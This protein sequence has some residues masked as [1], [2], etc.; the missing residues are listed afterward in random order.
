[1]GLLIKNG[2]VVTAE[3]LSVGDVRCREGR[4]VELGAGLPAAGERVVDASGQYV[5]PGGVD[6]HVHMELPVAGT[7]SSDDFETGTAAAL[8]G[9]TTTVIDFVHPERGE[10]F[11]SALAAR[12]R[13]AARSVIDYGLHMAVTWWGERTADWIA[14]CAADGV[15]SFK[16]YLAYKATVGIDDGD[17]LRAMAA[18]RRAG[19]VVLVHAEHGEAVEHLRDRFAAAGATHPRFHALSRPPALEGEATHRAATLAATAGASLYVVHVTCREAIAAVAAARE[20]GWAVDGETCPQY[21]MLDDRVYEADGFEGAAFVVA[22]PIRPRGHQEA[23]WEALAGGVLNAVGSDHCPF[24]MEQK[25]LGESD[26]RC[27]PGGAAG[28]EHRLALLYTYG[29]GAGR[30]SLERFVDLVATG[31]AKRFGLYPRKGAIEVGADADLVVWDPDA[32]GAIS[33][34]THHHRTDR[35]IYEGTELEGLPSWV[36]A[37][38]VVRLGPDGLDVERGAG[39]FLARRALAP[40]PD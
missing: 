3:G 1:M 37:N 6:P 18:V 8:A 22:P 30:L 2:T 21:L 16:I 38:G 32:T 23:L 27:I 4:I 34:A 24:T 29:V 40:R 31:P 39:R 26:F 20:L 10:D 35:S 5:F 17:V 33:A 14:R 12:R 28:V 19:G 15:P 13:A 11:A 25:R 7:V 9:G 36:I